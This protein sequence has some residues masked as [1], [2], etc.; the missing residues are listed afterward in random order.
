MKI[1]VTGGAGF[2][3]SHFIKHIINKYP[4]YD[5]ICVD[6]LTYAGRLEN[7]SSVMEH[8]R[9][10]FYKIDICSR[11]DI[12]SL[13]FALQ[14]DVVVNFAAESHVDRAIAAPSTCI[15]TNYVGTQILLDECVAC[16]VRRFHQVS[17][18]EVYGDLPLENDSEK[19]KE[20]SPLRPS[21]PYSASK[22][23]AD[24]LAIAYA[25]TYGLTVTI[26]RCSNNYGS[27]QHPEKFLPRMILNAHNNQP[28]P[29]YGSG[30]NI[31]DWIHVTDHCEAIDLI[32]H[33]GKSSEVYNVGSC[34]EFSNIILAKLICTELEKPYSLI[35]H[36]EDRKGHDLRYAINSQK[37]TK[38][39]GWHPKIDFQTGL[40]QTINW[41]I[42]QELSY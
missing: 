29:I 1:V 33:N 23:A 22:A 2:I 32:I 19:F 41:Y 17:T 27:F 12:S 26:S 10:A 40:R 7:L 28:L 15:Q 5:V 8:P 13:F 24:L 4:S 18:D 36:V 20:Y 37:L 9:F 11:H 31:R 39:L 38:D 42:H 6:K 21:S 3:G 14:P 25:R 16:G 35:K 34:C 30:L